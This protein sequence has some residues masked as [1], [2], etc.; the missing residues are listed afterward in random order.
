MLASQLADADGAALL[1]HDMVSLSVLTSRLEDSQAVQGVTVTDPSGNV[2]SQFGADVAP[3]AGRHFI[4]PVTLNGQDLGRVNLQLATPGRAGIVRRNLANLT[5]SAARHLS[6]LAVAL[7]LLSA[8]GQGEPRSVPAPRA[9]PLATPAVPE[10]EQPVASPV[11]LLHLG[12]DDPNNLLT[13]VNATTADELLTVLDHLLDRAARLYGGEI[14]APFSPAGTLVAFRQADAAERAF[15]AVLCGQL[16]LQLVAGADQQRRAAGLFSLPVKAGVH[17][18]GDDTPD[19]HQTAAILALA[20]PSGRLLSS[21]GSLAPEVLERCH[22]GQSLSLALGAGREL[23]IVVIER[24]QAEYQQ[25]VQNQ[26]Q[27][28]LGLNREGMVQGA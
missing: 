10:P 14:T 12:L 3:R 18:A 17:H 4:A 25:L 13:R 8:R 24:L 21:T 5:L 1:A 22:T 28:L 7:G 2:L 11:A 9:E 20:A 27:Q 15:Q 23:P 16:F 19:S 6:L 26:T